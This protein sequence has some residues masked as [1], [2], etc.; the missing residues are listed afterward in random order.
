[1]DRKA[2]LVMDRKAPLVM[3]LKAK[4]LLLMVLKAPLVMVLK[5]K[6]LLL[7]VLKAPLVMVLKAKALPLAGLLLRVVLLPLMVLPLV[8]LLLLQ[9]RGAAQAGSHAQ[10]GASSQVS[11]FSSAA[12]AIATCVLHAL[13][14][15]PSH[16]SRASCLAHVFSAPSPGLASPLRRKASLSG[17]PSRAPLPQARRRDTCALRM[18]STSASICV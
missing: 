16:V 9:H 7:M 3:V 14:N 6:V 4:A 18:A 12:D 15:R 8:L 2:P 13:R 5:A 1:M 10:P 17:R 11:R